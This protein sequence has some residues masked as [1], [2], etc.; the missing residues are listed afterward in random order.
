[1]ACVRCCSRCACKFWVALMAKEECRNWVH[2]DLQ[3][4]LNWQWDPLA[5][6]KVERYISWLA[7][8]C[9]PEDPRR[10]HS[11]F[12]S[13]ST[14]YKILSI[15]FSWALDTVWSFSIILTLW[16]KL[17]KSPCLSN[18]PGFD[19]HQ[20]VPLGGFAGRGF[21]ANFAILRSH[22]TFVRCVLQQILRW[23]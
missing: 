23:F 4:S 8:I 17:T 16:L 11:W 22:R 3:F 14:V 12:G 15:L 18:P 13:F 9:S 6:E 2:A 19:S 21:S 10:C 5:F 1:M 20:C 7:T